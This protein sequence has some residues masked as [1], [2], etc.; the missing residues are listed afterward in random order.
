MEM[1]LAIKL[2]KLPNTVKL[3]QNQF[4]THPTPYIQNVKILKIIGIRI[5]HFHIQIDEKV[6]FYLFKG[7]K[8]NFE[9]DI[10]CNKC[11]FGAYLCPT[12]TL[13]KIIFDKPKGQNTDFQKDMK[14]SN[15][16]VRQLSSYNLS[17]SIIFAHDI[18]KC[19]GIKLIRPKLKFIVKTINNN[20]KEFNLYYKKKV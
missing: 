1:I 6:Y 14:F 19:I 15:P 3:F 20:K 8:S 9:I 10:K 2:L 17:S 7:I 18:K 5:I 4:L 16:I 13:K 12:D 11:D